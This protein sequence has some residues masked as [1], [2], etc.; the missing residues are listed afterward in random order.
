ML[1]DR[2]DW[3]ISRQRDWGIPITLLYDKETGDT[4]PKQTEIFNQ[5]A[6]QIQSNGIDAWEELDLKFEKENFEKSK[7]IFD[8]WF[9]SGISHFCVID[10]LYGPN[11]QSDLYLE[12]SDQHRGWFQSSLLTS[13]AIKGQSP[14]KSVLTHGFVVDKD[15]KKMS[16]SIGNVVT[17]QEVI[18]TSGADILRYVSYTHLRA[19]ET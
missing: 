10:N 7:D 17:P 12:G 18:S 16:K 1:K 9:D 14:Y 4:H 19:H 13:I 8:V 11:T 6:K 2:P 5:A 15:G 3:C